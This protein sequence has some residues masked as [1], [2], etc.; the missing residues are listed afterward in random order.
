MGKGEEG[1]YWTTLSPPFPHRRMIKQDINIT[2][3]FTSVLYRAKNQFILFL[4]LFA[5]FCADCGFDV[6]KKYVTK[7]EET[8]VGPNSKAKDK[9][10]ILLWMRGP[11]EPGT[12]K[13]SP[14]TTGCKYISLF[15]HVTVSL[16]YTFC[17]Q[18]CFVFCLFCW[19]CWQRAC[20]QT[21]LVW[22]L[23][24]FWCYLE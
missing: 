3:H 2:I 22:L 4:S 24:Y 15:L 5:Y 13:P 17:V 11:Q 6:Y 20:C 18:C 12:K 14:A 21:C 10:G 23:N 8:C 1:W 7:V 16:I 9:K 19:W